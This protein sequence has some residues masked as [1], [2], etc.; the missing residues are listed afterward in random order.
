M[1]EGWKEASLAKIAIHNIRGVGG[2]A[3]P[4]PKGCSIRDDPVLDRIPDQ[5]STGPKFQIF[6]QTVL[7]IFDRSG[8]YLQQGADFPGRPTLGHQLQH[9]PLPRR[10]FE[11]S[12]LALAHRRLHLYGWDDNVILWGCAT[13]NRSPS[14]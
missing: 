4:I 7:M 3:K 1:S 10:E 6:H 5:L 8:G 2:K 12:L 14:V 9:L 13:I 11:N